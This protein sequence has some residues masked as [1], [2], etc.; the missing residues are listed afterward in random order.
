MAS[1]LSLF[2][3]VIAGV[4]AA[5]AV[6][7]ACPTTDPTVP[8]AVAC[9]SDYF[10]TQVGTTFVYGGLSIPMM[11]VGFGPGGADTI[12]ER[13]TDITIGAAPPPP[14][15]PDL[16]MTGL[17]LE[18]TAPVAIPGLG[19]VPIYVSLNPANLAS[20]TG[21]AQILPWPGQTPSQAL[22]NGGTFNSSLNVNYDICTAVG[23]NG[24]GCGGGTSI[25]TGELALSQTGA[26]WSPVA[27]AG[28]IIVAGTDEGPGD[29]AANCHSTNCFVTGAPTSLG[30]NEVDFFPDTLAGSPVGPPPGSPAC[31][32]FVAGGH[33]FMIPNPTHVWGIE[34]EPTGSKHIVGGKASGDI[35]KVVEGQDGISE[36]KVL[37]TGDAATI[38]LINVVQGLTQGDPTDWADITGVGGTCVLGA[39]LP[40][41]A[42]CTVDVSFIT[43]ALDIGPLYD[44]M[45]PFYLTFSLTNINGTATLDATQV[46]LVS[47][48][49]PAGLA[50]LA[51]GL[52]GLG[53]LRRRRAVRR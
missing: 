33:C 47:D 4:I 30:P 15:A 34:G 2:A 24:V 40:A 45:T 49:E 22:L 16:L 53:L 31:L 20:D 52:A 38:S 19:D 39:V 9:G 26:P 41:G 37:N 3:A 50:V 27:A 25:A 13:T 10:L 51:T 17:Q 44:G 6:A 5:P 18:S 48:P 23:T 7:L 8:A 28:S 14:T 36:F 35:V 32:Q 42:G 43:D 12:V 11:G 1:R 29:Q 46:V 21:T